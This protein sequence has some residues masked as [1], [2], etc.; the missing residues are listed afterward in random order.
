MVTGLV[1]FWVSTPAQEAASIW[2]R[3]SAVGTVGAALA[4]AAALWLTQRDSKRRATFE[5]LREIN[6]RMQALDAVDVPE[7]QT[8]LLRYFR[9]HSDDYPK[10]GRA[11][12]SLLDALE[13]LAFAI[14]KKA[15]DRRIATEYAHTLLLGHMAPYIFL[16]DFQNACGDPYVYR[17]LLRLVGK[18]GIETRRERRA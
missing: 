16:H 14:E 8:G 4:A 6:Q 9:H 2:E 18:L 7:V 13:L 5:H 11:Y 10:A 1:S 15:V 12:L 3:G 17:H